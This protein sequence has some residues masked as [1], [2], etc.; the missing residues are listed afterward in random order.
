MTSVQPPANH[1]LQQLKSASQRPPYNLAPIIPFI[2]LFL[3]LFLTNTQGVPAA[4]ASAGL[5]PGV[6]SD[7]M[8]DCED[9]SP[10]SI[11]SGQ[12]P[13]HVWTNTDSAH[14]RRGF[15]E[16]QLQQ[17][18]RQR[19]QHSGVL[20]QSDAIRVTAGEQAQHVAL[21][22]FVTNLKVLDAATGPPA[23]KSDQ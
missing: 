5:K 19:H 22:V 1:H 18:Q 7:H 21:D 9:D 17:V 12:P 10:G 8:P 16:Q 11:L 3:L 4:A 20:M 6:T 15:M 23:G 13:L 2:I 14:K